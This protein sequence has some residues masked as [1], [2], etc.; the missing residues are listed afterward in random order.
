MI[1]AHE[2][3]INLLDQ[4]QKFTEYDFCLVHLLDE[5]EKYRDYFIKSKISGRTIFLDNS[6]FELG[7]PY[8]EKKYRYWINELNPLYY[9][10]PADNNSYKRTIDITKRWI[11]NPPNSFSSPIAVCVGNTK[12]EAMKCFVKLIEIPSVRKIGIPF[13]L[14]CFLSKEK[15]H[16]FPDLENSIRN[17]NKKGIENYFEYGVKNNNLI[18]D[19]NKEFLSDTTYKYLKC[20]DGRI[21]LIR[22]INNSGLLTYREIDDELHPSVSLHFLGCSLP[23]EM[24]HYKNSAV[25]SEPLHTFSSV[26]TS[27]PVLH[28]L[29]NIK[30]APYGLDFKIGKK[31]FELISEPINQSQ[32]KDVVYN[33]KSFRKFCNGVLDEKMDID[34]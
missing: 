17:E 25:M 33:M 23:Q 22:E 10:V 30:Y 9:V 21:N 4:I 34:F 15:I 29:Y 20:M 3:P 16:I 1:I 14:N 13:D 27:N 28:G 19:I 26:D 8:D 6:C 7:E 11:E 5:Q 31:M 32:I 24:A 18:F 2:C 12:K